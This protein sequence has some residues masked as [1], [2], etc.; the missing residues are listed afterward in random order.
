MNKQAVNISIKMILAGVITLFV[1]YLLNIEY[2]TTAAA[3]SILSIQLTKRD[4]ITIAIKRIISGIAAIL[5]SALLFMICLLL[6]N[7]REKASV[8]SL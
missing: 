2:Y 4:F 8:V 1:T 5:F 3:V 7:T 6:P